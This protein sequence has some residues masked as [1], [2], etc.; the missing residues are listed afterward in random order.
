MNENLCPCCTKPLE[1]DGRYHC[2]ECDKHFNKIGFCPSCESE[3]EKLQ[4]C[5][6]ANYFCNQCNELKSKSKIRFEFKPQD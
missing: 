1:W 2:S 6:A 5:G 4:A 3:L